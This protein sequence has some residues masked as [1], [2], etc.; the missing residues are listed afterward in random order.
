MADYLLLEYRIQHTLH[1]S[2]HILNCLVDN[3]VQ[4]KV[5]ALLLSKLL[6]CGIRTYVKSDDDGI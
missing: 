3:L 5:Y 4:T 2:F 6:R 1:G